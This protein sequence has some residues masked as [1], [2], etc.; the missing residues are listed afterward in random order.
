MTSRREIFNLM[1][2]NF[3]QEYELGP[4]KHSSHIKLE[5]SLRS[6]YEVITSNNRCEIEIRFLL[7]EAPRA[8]TIDEVMFDVQERV[9]EMLGLNG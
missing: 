9:K 6:E 1:G 4:F 5:V 8:I 2:E 7:W 3:R